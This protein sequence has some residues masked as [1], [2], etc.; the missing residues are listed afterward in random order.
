MFC[1]IK[2]VLLLDSDGEKLYGK[3]F[4]P[5]AE[6]QSFASQDLFEKQLKSKL[7]KFVLKHKENEVVLVEN[8]TVVLKMVNNLTLYI[9]GSSEENE[10]FLGTVLDA[11][12]EALDLVYHGEIERGKVIE[13]LELVMLAIDEMFEDGNI[14]AFDATAIAEKVLM[15]EISENAPAKSNAKESIFGRALQNAKQ[16]ISKTINS[17]K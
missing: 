16:A 10:I 4:N 12:A 6:L 7:S 14:L 9:L 17:R 8:I 11:L 3:Y 2:G 15:R 13:E 5:P 1:E